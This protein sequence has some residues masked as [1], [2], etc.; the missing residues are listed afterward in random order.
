[1]SFEPLDNSKPFGKLPDDSKPSR[2]RRDGRDL[3]PKTVIAADPAVHTH[4]ESDVT[5]L[6]SYSAVGHTHTESEITDLAHVD[7][8]DDL[9]DVDTTTVAPTDGQVLT[10]DNANSVWEPAT[11]S[12]GGASDIDDL[13]DVDTSTSAP[14]DGQALLWV[15]ADSEW[16]PGDV[17]A[18]GGGG[19]LEYIST[20][21]LSSTGVI[22]LPSGYTGFKL[23]VAAVGSSNGEIHLRAGNGSIDTGSNYSGVRHYYGDST[24]NQHVIGGTSAEFMHVDS[25]GSFILIEIG[26]DYAETGSRTAFHGWSSVDSGTLMLGYSGHARYNVTGAIDRIELVPQSITLTGSAYL[27]GYNTTPAAGTTTFYAYEEA[28]SP[29]TERVP[30]PYKDSSGSYDTFTFD[31]TL[32]TPITLT[33][34]DFEVYGGTGADWSITIGGTAFGTAQT[35]PGTTGDVTFTDTMALGAGTVEVVVSATVSTNIRFDDTAGNQD[36][37]YITVGNWQEATNNTPPIGF[38]FK[39]H[40]YKEFT[41]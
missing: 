21:D 41:V 29:T 6:G 24:G 9:S 38:T 10:W 15:A 12:G 5:D 26:P 14:T 7:S 8:I 23:M 35:A 20:T 37:G 25:N 34:V 32:D 11:P 17:A 31:I 28:A 18:S 36:L 13:S 22:T 1:M 16:Q 30:T 27:Y 2:P 40:T 19:S 4:T 3:L 33:E 39:P